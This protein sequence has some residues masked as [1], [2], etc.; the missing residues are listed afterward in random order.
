MKVLMYGTHPYEKPY[1]EKWAQ[2]TQTELRMVD[3]P[4]NDETVKLAKDFDAIT[5]LQTA[6]MGSPRFTKN[7]PA[8]A[9]SRSAAAW[10]ASTWWIWMPPRPTI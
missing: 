2:Q 10:S 3:E 9:S 7:W 5:V 8:L 6:S 4:L 1:A